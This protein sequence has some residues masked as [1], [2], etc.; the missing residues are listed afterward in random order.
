MGLVG[1][2]ITNLALAVP[3]GPWAED[4]P[5]P[6]RMSPFEVPDEGPPSL[7]ACT[8]GFLPRGVE[9]PALDD[10][11][12]RNDARRSWGTQELIDTIIVGTQEVAWKF[13]EADPVFVG[14]M[15]RRQGG[16]LGPHREHQSGLDADIGLFTLGRKQPAQFFEVVR[17]ADLDAEATLTFFL[18]LIDTGRV[19]YILLDPQ[20]IAKL[21]KYALTRTDLTRAEVD[22]IFAP[23]GQDW[24]VKSVVRPAASHRNHFHL[25]VACEKPRQAAAK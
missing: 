8:E 2:L 11:Y 6:N 21:R 23:N 3:Q 1:F 7:P 24:R 25:H 14:D 20:L 12:H 10:L 4:P 19:G 17:P 15:S 22:A 5:D 13:P 16:R 9:L 18:A